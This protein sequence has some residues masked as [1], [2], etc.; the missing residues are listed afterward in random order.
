MAHV[1]SRMHRLR[2]RLHRS[3]SCICKAHCVSAGRWKGT[4]VAVKILQH[5]IAGQA[6]NIA[7]AREKMIGLASVHPNVVSVPMESSVVTEINFS[8]LCIVCAPARCTLQHHYPL[9]VVMSMQ[10]RTLRTPYSPPTPFFSPSALPAKADTPLLASM[11]YIACHNA[12]RLS[13]GGG[14]GC[15]TYRD[16]PSRL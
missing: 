10:P 12:M 1:Q 2:V 3:L 6:S 11:P 4:N 15:C 9:H 8:L 7:V 5:G 14:Q 16:L 13:D